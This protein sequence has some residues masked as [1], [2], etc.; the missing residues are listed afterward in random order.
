MTAVVFR[1]SDEALT[2]SA[3]RRF[4]TRGDIE[5]D[6]NRADVFRSGSRTD[7]EGLGNLPVGLAVH[8]KA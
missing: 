1:G 5:L 8:Q 4:T 6:Q 2:Q 3:N 7:E